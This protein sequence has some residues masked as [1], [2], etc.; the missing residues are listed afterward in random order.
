MIKV[1]GKKRILVLACLL[2]INILF[3]AIVYLYLV[4]EKAL[5]EKN[6]KSITSKVKTV[7]KDLEFTQQEFEQLEIQKVQFEKLRTK[8]FFNAQM[9]RRAEEIFEQIQK[10]SEVASAKASIGAGKTVEN[11]D[12][13][14]SEH[15][16]LESPVHIEIEAI[17]D[18]DVYNY[19]YLLQNFFPGHLTI[20][21][22]SMGRQQEVTG[23]VLK[24]I[25]TGVNPPLVAAKIDMIWRTMIPKTEVIDQGEGKS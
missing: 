20:S 22:V 25:A 6:L 15:V 16:L 24:A 11:E 10:Q 3:G 19:I 5:Q 18:V 21:I 17:N 8:G 14:K 7:R 2:G 12:A 23:G 1:L 9:R 13:A 4:P